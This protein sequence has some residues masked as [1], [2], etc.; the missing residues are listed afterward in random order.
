MGLSDAQ[1]DRIERHMA[2][3]LDAAEAA[4]LERDC[5]ADTELAQALADAKT[6]KA[7]A[8]AMRIQELRD[9]LDAAE[10]AKKRPRVLPLV[11]GLAAAAL[12]ALLVWVGLLR[13]PAFVGTAD[14]VFAQWEGSS[15][16]RSDSAAS[17]AACVAYWRDTLPDPGDSLALALRH[18]RGERNEAAAALLTALTR[19]ESPRGREALFFLGLT[20]ARMGQAAAARNSLNAYL[21]RPGAI[22]APEAARLLSQL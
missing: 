19:E 3:Q 12:L 7:L 15:T 22:H 8:R 16:D 4:Q 2:G 14:E 17:N 5:A 6:V 9:V 18:M 21:E 20:E 11:V 13:T 1:Y 10:G